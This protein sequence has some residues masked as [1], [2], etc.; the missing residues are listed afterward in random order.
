MSGFI[1]NFDCIFMKTICVTVDTLNFSAFIPKLEYIYLQQVVNVHS[2]AI[3]YCS[4][5][6][7][8]TIKF[9]LLSECQK[10]KVLQKVYL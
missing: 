10:F 8:C 1:Q 7:S 9:L 2:R 6:K 5:F 3:L 4:E